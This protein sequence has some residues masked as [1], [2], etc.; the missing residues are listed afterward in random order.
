MALKA[1]GAAM[2][3]RAHVTQRLI[4]AISSSRSPDAAVRQRDR[5]SLTALEAQFSYVILALEQDA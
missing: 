2:A 4:R 3:A 1:R 5:T